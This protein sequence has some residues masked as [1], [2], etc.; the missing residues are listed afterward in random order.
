[1]AAGKKFAVFDIDG[2]LFR[3][4]LF[5]ELVEELT[6][7]ENF[8]EDDFLKFD[9][10]WKKWRGGEIS[11]S[12]YERV[13]VTVFYTYLPNIPIDTYLKACW[14]V[15]DRSGHK[16]YLFTKKLLKRLQTE[17]VV[18]IAISGSQQEI[19]DMF[20][21]RYG[22]DHVF[23]TLYERKNGAFTGKEARATYGRKH[24]IL[25]DLIKQHGLTAKGSVGIGDSDSDIQMLEMVEQPIAFNPSEKLFNYA[26][27]A[28]WQVVLERKNI[29]YTLDNDDGSYILAEAKPY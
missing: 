11:F 1:M 15:V 25:K 21:D 6:L 9:D 23:G 28:G 29:V 26:K 13:V 3:W 4:Q 7:E 27:L 12:D 22:F 17:G 16:S 19:V 24:L 14:R 2:T 5:H 8:P 18:T 20:A 10:A